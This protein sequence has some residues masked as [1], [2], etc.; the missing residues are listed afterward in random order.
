MRETDQGF[1]RLQDVDK[2]TFTRFVEFIYTGN[3]NAPQPSPTL[4]ASA[5][6][7]DFG[8][9]TPSAPCETPG[10]MPNDP[11]EPIS[12]QLLR[13]IRGQEL[14][15]ARRTEKASQNIRHIDPT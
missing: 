6:D 12:D 11:I 7:Q 8:S 10:H 1:A 13:S 14:W 2:M 15:K 4:E 3:Y 9:N 5:D